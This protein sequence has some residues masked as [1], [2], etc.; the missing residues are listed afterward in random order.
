MGENEL[1][2]SFII[3]KALLLR[4][5][6]A[7]V[8]VSHLSGL[9]LPGIAEKDPAMPQETS[10]PSVAL[11]SLLPMVISTFSEQAKML[12]EASC[13]ASALKDKKEPAAP[14][15]KDAKEQN[16]FSCGFLLLN[17]SEGTFSG[18]KNTNYSIVYLHNPRIAATLITFYTML[19][20]CF[21]ILD[22]LR[23]LQYFYLLPR[24]S[25][26]DASIVYTP[27]VMMNPLLP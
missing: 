1:L 7:I 5:F 27:I 4:I 9:V 25:I 13:L 17:V 23:I 8:I 20:L 24:G 19:L 22:R 21:L 3:M 12:V 10:A 16:R 15:K 26:D 2:F 6:I 11:S 14:Q 18:N